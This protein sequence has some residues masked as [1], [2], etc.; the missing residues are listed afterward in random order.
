MTICCH[1]ACALI[2]TSFSITNIVLKKELWDLKISHKWDNDDYYTYQ[3]SLIHYCHTFN[4]SWL[5]SSIA[6]LCLSCSCRKESKTNK[7]WLTLL[8][9]LPWMIKDQLTDWDTSLNLKDIWEPSMLVGMN[10][11]SDSGSSKTSTF[12]PGEK[13]DP[14]ILSSIT[15]SSSSYRSSWKNF[16]TGCM[17]SENHPMSRNTLRSV[18]IT[19]LLFTKDWREFWNQYVFS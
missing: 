3:F 11:A 19:R 12:R 14:K 2:L 17:S 1:T 6:M 10:M 13:L 16:C 4:F 15:S 5:M 8:I 18:S 9:T 7:N